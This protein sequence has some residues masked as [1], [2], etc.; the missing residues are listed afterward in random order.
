MKLS[1][2][3]I[4]D[5]T[6]GAVRIENDSDV[7]S[8]YRFTTE[9]EEFY[10]ARNKDSYIKS[11]ASAG[12][13]LLFKTDSTTLEFSALIKP[14]S[15]RKFFSYDVYVDGKMIGSL[16]N[17]KGIEIPPAYSTFPFA[18]NGEVSG[19]FALGEGIKTVCVYFPWSYS[20]S[21]TEISI[22][23][24]A[25]VEPV[26]HPKKMIAFGDS[27]T[28]GYDSLYT[29][30][31]YITKLAVALNAELIN[32]AIGGEFYASGLSV[33]KDDASPDYITVAYGTNDWNAKDAESFKTNCYDFLHNL[34][35]MYPDAKIIA[36]API[37][38]RNYTEARAFGAF[39]D[40]EKIIREAAN[41]LDNV[42]VIR[43]FDF[44]PK[45]EAYFADLS[46]HPNDKGFTCYSA[47]LIDEVS[48]LIQL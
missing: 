6:E 25:F 32:K 24:G 3:Q 11:L 41:G 4:K 30:N 5:I 35:N 40:V 10:K 43:G 18:T 1:F 22:D 21:I 37:W 9:Q 20:T 38:R 14:A 13:K 2:E 15:S 36:I 26:K 44:V 27:I 29:S 17:F 47:N 28:Q 45:D 33:L 42:Y 23:N 12:V 31:A 34:S 16:N 46:L 39:D 7:V 8:F 19:K 48:K